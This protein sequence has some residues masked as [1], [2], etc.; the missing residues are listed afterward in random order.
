MSSSYSAQPPSACLDSV[1]LNNHATGIGRQPETGIP[2]QYVLVVDAPICTISRK[3]GILGRTI[4]VQAYIRQS[5][6]AASCLSIKNT[7]N[8]DWFSFQWDR[9][10]MLHMY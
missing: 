7:F 6:G 8:K 3:R 5:R 4:L 1:A 10:L 9:T 2:R